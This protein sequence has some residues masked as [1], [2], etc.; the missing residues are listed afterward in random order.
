MNQG[1]ADHSSSAAGLNGAGRFGPCIACERELPLRLPGPGEKG[2][3]WV[4][5]GCGAL[6][7]AMFDKS[8]AAGLARNVRPVS[9]SF[10]RSRLVQPPQAIAEFLH[11]LKDESRGRE[12][13]RQAARCWMVTHVA[14]VP[15][16]KEF[17]PVGEPF[18]AVTRNIS[19]RG[20]A[21]VHTR[22]VESELVVVELTTGSG[23]AIQLVMRV[24][25]CRPMGR[26]Y[27][28]AG[29]FVVRIA[30]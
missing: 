6:Y 24:A 11:R 9:V 17:R 22:A 4:C 29:P 15:V 3:A 1:I 5:T 21:L 2:T 14:A 18:M 16:D 20:L 25:R 7:H 13:R 12:D 19:T 26:F 28:V 23:S 8:T 10:D 30:A 27:E